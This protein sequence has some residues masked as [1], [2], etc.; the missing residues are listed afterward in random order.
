MEN[1][2][3]Q[4]LESPSDA[5]QTFS[6]RAPSMPR[7]CALRLRPCRFTASAQLAEAID[8]HGPLHAR[9]SVRPASA[10]AARSRGCSSS[11]ASARSAIVNWTR[12]RH[13]YPAPRGARRARRRREG[14]SC[15]TTSRS[16]AISSIWRWRR[17]SR[18]R[19]P[20]STASARPIAS[21][22][23]PAITTPMSAP[24]LIASAKPSRPILRGD[25]GRIGFP[26]CA[27]A[28]RSR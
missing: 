19:A 5:V 9:P 6:H 12:N 25:D 8:P 20:G 2:P 22:P 10:A 1:S 17:S 24:P 15:P 18:R 14:A 3:Q 27:G 11:P 21:P 13:K 23:F 16:P 4:R 26:A 28:G 7:A